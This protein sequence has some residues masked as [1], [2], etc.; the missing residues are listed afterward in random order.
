MKD[1]K[2]ALVSGANRGIGKEVV[3]QLAQLNYH[4]FLGARDLKVNFCFRSSCQLLCFG[5]ARIHTRPCA[6]K[7]PAAPIQFSAGLSP[8]S[9]Q[10]FE[11]AP[12]ESFRTEHSRGLPHR[13]FS[14][15]SSAETS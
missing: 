3:R 7:N 1:V 6:G 11:A 14:I 10:Y 2:V 4:V 15:V 13:Q 12:G 8:A 5:S 9:I